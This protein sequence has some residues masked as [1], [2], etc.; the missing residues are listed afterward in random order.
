MRKVILSHQIHPHY[1]RGVAYLGLK[2]ISQAPCLDLSLKFCAF[3]LASG[4]ADTEHHVGEDALLQPEHY[5]DFFKKKKK[6]RNKTKQKNLQ[7]LLLC[8]ASLKSG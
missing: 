5:A 7:F 3:T 1:D 2:P 4:S 6:P 8:L